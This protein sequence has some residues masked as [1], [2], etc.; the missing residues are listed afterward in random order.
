MKIEHTQSNGNNTIRLKVFS[1]LFRHLVNNLCL[2][3]KITTGKNPML[4]KTKDK[5]WNNYTVELRY[6]EGPKFRR[7]RLFFIYFRLFHILLVKRKAIVPRVVLAACKVGR[8]IYIYFEKSWSYP[9][10]P[11]GFVACTFFWQPFSK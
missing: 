3:F 7:S 4:Y 2:V 11:F 6:N 10:L 1:S 8:P 9:I 5:R